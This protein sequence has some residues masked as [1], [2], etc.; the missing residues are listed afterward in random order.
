[1]L[2]KAPYLIVKKLSEI[3]GVQPIFNALI[4]NTSK[5]AKSAE[6]KS[7]DISCTRRDLPTN[8]LLIDDLFETGDTA[9]I[10]INAIK[11]MNPRCNI[12]FV[13]CTKNKF[14][15]MPKKYKATI[16]DETPYG[17]AKNG[18][19]FIR[20]R[21]S[22]DGNLKNICVFQN[23]YPEEYDRLKGAHSNKSTRNNEITISAKKNQKGYW[24]FKGMN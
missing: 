2:E 24:T 17:I 6:L 15:G 12:T 23:D 20:L 3:S 10:S 7:E 5:Q 1:M 19:P 11:S 21:V 13:S 22:I 4:K 16:N 14:G 9:R 8:L 18:V